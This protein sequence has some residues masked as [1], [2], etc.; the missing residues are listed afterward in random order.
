MHRH[1]F[2]RFAVSA[3][4]WQWRRLGVGLLWLALALRGEAEER[5]P[6]RVMTDYWPPFRIEGQDGR[7]GGLDMDLLAELERRTGLR[8]EVQRAPWARGLAALQSGAADMMTGLARTPA[9]AH[10]IDYLPQP[11]YACAPRLY[12]S[13]EVAPSIAHYDDLRGRTIGYVLE[14]AYFEPFD[15]DTRLKK[16]GVSNEAQLLQ[17]LSLGRLQLVIGT[18]CQVDY[19]RR[20]PRLAERVVRTR[21]QPESRTDL[22][23]GF[24]RQRPLVAERQLIEEALRQLLAEGWVQRA[25]GRYQPEAR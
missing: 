11:Y 15:S 5:P 14:S 16:F 20:D 17:M 4:A 10:Y 6:L 19:E 18:D 3:R 24:S 9:R 12:G 7:I 25:A 23:I 1:P 21:F 2:A 22:Y 13:Q 8:F